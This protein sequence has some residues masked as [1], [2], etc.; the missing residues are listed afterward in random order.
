MNALF[1]RSNKTLNI[2]STRRDH[3]SFDDDENDDDDDDDTD[4][5][6]NDDN[7]ND[8][9]SNESQ[10]N[11][12]NE[13][14]ESEKENDEEK[15]KNERNEKNENENDE[16]NDDD[17]KNENDENENV[18]TNESALAIFQR[19][20]DVSFFSSESVFEL[21]CN[22]RL[23]HVNVTSIKRKKNDAMNNENELTITS[24]KRRRVS[25]A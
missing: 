18:K 23:T 22:S 3:S 19:L 15:K 16:K 2:R 7:E 12:V 17:D 1:L 25:D 11:D 21:R 5:N 20:V 6:N 8:D 10:N 4:E 13:S 24:S 14:S 9:E